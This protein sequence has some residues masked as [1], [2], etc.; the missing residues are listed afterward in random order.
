PLEED[1]RERVEERRLA[2]ERLRHAVRQLGDGGAHADAADVRD[3]AL[4]L[5]AAPL[6]VRHAAHVDRSRHT[7]DRDAHGVLEACRDVVGADEVHARAERDRRELSVRARAYEA[8]DDLVQRAVAPDGHDDPR[9][10]S[11]GALRELDQMSRALGEE[12]LPLEPEPGG[13]VRKLRPAL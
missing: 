13:A 12:R 5:R 8:V 2:A 4:A 9:A 10:V 3:V 11:R 6:A 1:P 7:T